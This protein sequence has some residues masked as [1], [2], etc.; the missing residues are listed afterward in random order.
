MKNKRLL[1]ACMAA[2]LAASSLTACAGGKTASSGDNSGKTESTR[3]LAGETTTGAAKDTE[4]ENPKEESPKGEKTVLTVWHTWGA[5]PGTDAMEK[6]VDMYNQTNDKNV[7]INL[8]FVANKASGNTQT[9]DKLMA[10]IAAGSPPEM[11][12]LDNFQVA[13]WAQQ[14]ALVKLDDLMA[15]SGTSFDGIYDWAKS[16]SQYKGSTYSIPY[17]G[18]TR[19]LFYNKDLFAAA[20]LDPENPPS[21]I[22]ELNAAAEKLTIMEGSTY[23]QVGIIPWLFAGKPIYTWGWNFGGDFYDADANVLTIAK[24][25]NIEALQWEVDVADK[26]G[27]KSFVE[28]AAGLGTGAQDPFVTGQVAMAVK[29]NFDIANMAQY[30]PDLNYGICPIPSKEEGK[31][32]TWAG[33]WAFVIPRG[34]GNQ[35]L[36][37]DFM[38][39]ILSD[40]AQT[41]MAE[42]SASLSPCKSVSEKV[43]GSKDNYKAFMDYISTAKIRPPVPVGQMLW[44]NLN[45][46]LDS[47]LNKKDTPENLMKALDVSINEEL[48][49]LE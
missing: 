34:A 39:Y 16:G 31:H 13:T 37:M 12:L 17:N 23:K 48:K 10:S 32:M 26:F 42:D 28:F 2:L 21:T 8:Q 44:D 27:G 1:A 41:V 6:V 45:Q 43:F 36:S 15:A 7:E 40:E 30:N 14:D 35:E 19:A 49:K 22:E 25:E 5:G 47:A 11:A 20:G 3:A 9:M 4:G 46:V 33:G 38:K 18:D 24:A 29:G